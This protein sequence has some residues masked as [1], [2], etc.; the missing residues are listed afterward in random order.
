VI[1]AVAMEPLRVKGKSEPVQ[2]YRVL[3]RRNLLPL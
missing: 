2:I 3:A 1:E